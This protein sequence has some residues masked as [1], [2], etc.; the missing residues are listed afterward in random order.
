VI[1]NF[2]GNHS[3]QVSQ[4]LYLK[5]MQI[6]IEA[7]TGITLKVGGNFITIDP[8]GVAISGMPAVLINSGGAALTGS[9]GALVSPLPPLE[10]AVADNADPG[11]MQARSGSQAGLAKSAGLSVL[12]DA[13]THDPRSA[14]NKD[15]KHW[16]EIE[17]LD[18]DDNPVPGETY[19][20]TLPDG[21]TVASGTLDHKGRARVDHI[22]PGTCQVTF[23]KLDKDAWQPK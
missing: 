23:P 14:K 1:E 12:P 20:I 3:S 16:I 10:A 13:P 15:K 19:R 6:V 2:Q 18:E 21:T 22:D 4:D 8:S 9:A 17:L 7:A 11:A 5:A